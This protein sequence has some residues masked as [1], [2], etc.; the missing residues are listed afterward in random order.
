MHCIVAY[1][2]A[3]TLAHSIHSSPAGRGACLGEY[4]DETELDPDVIN[5]TRRGVAR[6][7]SSLK[8][9]GDILCRNG[10]KDQRVPENEVISIAGNPAVP[11]P[12]WLYTNNLPDHRFHLI[13]P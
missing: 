7:M 1:L 11:R 9:A 4:G 2:L 13:G 5:I 8:E 10:L 12:C 6:R 3:R